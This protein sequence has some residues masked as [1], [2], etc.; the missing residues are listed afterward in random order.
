MVHYDRVDLH[1]VVDGIYYTCNPLE[2]I[3]GFHSRGGKL[4]QCHVVANF[5]GG[6]Q[7]QSMG[8]ALKDMRVIVE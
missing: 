8:E 2:F 3:S 1:N 4:L 7:I 5:G 6:R